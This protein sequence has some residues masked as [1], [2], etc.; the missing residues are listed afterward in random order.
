MFAQGCMMRLMSNPSCSLHTA[1]R[2][3]P[4]Q[5]SVTSVLYH[6]F[7]NSITRSGDHKQSTPN[8]NQL[9]HMP[10]FVSGVLQ[11]LGTQV[12]HSSWAR[13][14]IIGTHGSI[15]LVTCV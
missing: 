9:Q 10:R 12:P 8:H 4:G 13:V 11:G 7:T 14:L 15:M 3:V 5:M 6:S 1:S 2:A